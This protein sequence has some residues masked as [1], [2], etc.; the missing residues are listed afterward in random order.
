MEVVHSL[1]QQVDLQFKGF[2]SCFCCAH[3][4]GGPFSSIQPRPPVLMLRGWITVALGDFFKFRHTILLTRQVIRNI[5]LKAH[6]AGWL[7]LLLNG[8]IWYIN[9]FIWQDNI[10]VTPI[11]HNPNCTFCSPGGRNTSIVSRS[12]TA[13][14]G[15]NQSLINAWLTGDSSKGHL[16]TTHMLPTQML[17]VNSLDVLGQCLVCGTDGEAIYVNRHV[18]I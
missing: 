16:E 3:S 11:I 9:L 10:T 1:K 4:V 2:N 5:F 8:S 17:S 18:P 7:C 15:G 12:A 13:P 14:A 6:R